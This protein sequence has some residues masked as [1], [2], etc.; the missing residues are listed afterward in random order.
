M[1]A[2]LMYRCRN[3]EG[4]FVCE[5]TQ[6]YYTLEEREDMR[7]SCSFMSYEPGPD[8]VRLHFDNKGRGTLCIDIGA[9]FV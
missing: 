1:C 7:S 8:G 9:F 2:L 5:C 4:S 3:T 6:G